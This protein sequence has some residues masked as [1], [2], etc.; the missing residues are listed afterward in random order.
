MISGWWF[1][2]FSNFSSPCVSTTRTFRP[3]ETAHYVNFVQTLSPIKRKL[4]H[5]ALAG[6]IALMAKLII[7]WDLDAE[8]MMERGL[9][10]IHR[11]KRSS[12]VRAQILARQL[13]SSSPEEIEFLRNQ[14]RLKQVSDDHGLTI[15]LDKPFSRFLPQTYV[16]ASFLL[17]LCPPDQIVALPQ[18]LR[19]LTQIYPAEITRQI[20][21]DID[22]TH[23]EKLYHSKPQLAFIADYSHPCRIQTIKNLGIQ[24]FNLKNI[25]SVQEI[26]EAL[27]RVGHLINR[28]LEAELLTLFMESSLIAIDNRIQILKQI[29]PEAAMTQF[30]YLNYY[31]QFCLPSKN[32]LPLQFLRRTHSH[33]LL[34]ADLIQEYDDGLSTPL[35]YERLL[36]LNPK[37]LLLSTHEENLLKKKIYCNPAFAGLTA[38][39]SDQIFFLDASIQESPTQYIVLAY[40]DLFKAIES[41]YTR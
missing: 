27:Y 26:Y 11:L 30:L 13:L 21:L 4:I 18:G 14:F 15:S 40:F 8:I 3:K 28:P 22:L 20:P 31:T 32:S 24:L 33:N 1:C 10:S 16:S 2:A 37:C 36:H 23:S 34:I 38:Q 17:A 7:D 35:S 41:S 19:H 5:Q 12:F 29:F 39:Q 9:S 25:N 6:D